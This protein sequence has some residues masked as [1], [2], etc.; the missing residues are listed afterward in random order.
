M[1]MS[2]WGWACE[3]MAWAC[4]QEGVHDYFGVSIT[5]RWA[6]IPCAP[7]SSLPK[8]TAAG[9]RPEA[10]LAAWTRGAKERSTGQ[11]RAEESGEG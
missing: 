10:A 6:A 5:G 3:P 2:T 4:E 9:R 11:S 7:P 8:A 1:S